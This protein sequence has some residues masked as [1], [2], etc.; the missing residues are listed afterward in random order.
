M[1]KMAA[2]MPEQAHVIRNDP[3]D[4]KI[5]EALGDIARNL[6]TVNSLADAEIALDAASEILGVKWTCWNGD[7]NRPNTCPEAM[8]YCRS[9]GWPDDV[10]NF[11]QN[12]YEALKIPTFIR[13]R[14]E[15]LPFSVSFERADDG[16]SSASHIQYHKL[17]HGL[18][19]QT[20]LIVPIHLPK[21]QVGILGW[22]GDIP[23][24]V[25]ESVAS[26]ISMELLAIGH[27]FMRIYRNVSGYS[28]ATDEEF[29]RLTPREW[30]CLR[31]LAQGYREPDAAVVLGLT[32]STVR[33]HLNNVVKKFGCKNR[34]QA[35]A[36]AAQLGLLGPIG[37]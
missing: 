6:Y 21:G 35:I 4:L 10:L 7:T 32:K 23:C 8:S 22:L 29:S 17:L 5:R 16:I 37:V 15:H 3:S 9:R 13:C 2:L 19:I 24:D 28:S 36:L 33:F 26:S 30:D 27:H 1:F 18:G 11:W 12:N 34:T 14:F 25:L 20:A 31:I